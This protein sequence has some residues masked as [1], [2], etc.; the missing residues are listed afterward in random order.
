[1]LTALQE[2]ATR[3]SVLQ[4]I[5]IKHVKTNTLAFRFNGHSPGGPG[6]AGTRKFPFWSLLELRMMD[7]VVT[8]ENVKAPVKMSPSTNQYP[9]FTG[10]MPC[11]SPNQQC[12]YT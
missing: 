7:V 8:T 10:K 12:T 11:L 1:M 5:P 9:V 3:D 4:F 6:L 2:A